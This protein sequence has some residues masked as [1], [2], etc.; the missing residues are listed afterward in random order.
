M[1]N[2]GV[3]KISAGE[4]VHGQAFYHKGHTLEG[5]ST[6]R[7]MS[8][9]KLFV[10]V[11]EPN[12]QLTCMGGLGSQ[13]KQLHGGC[14]HLRKALSKFSTP[15][16]PHEA[17]VKNL[18]E[19]QWVGQPSAPSNC[20]SKTKL[21]EDVL[22]KQPSVPPNAASETELGVNMWLH[23][24]SFPPCAAACDKELDEN[25]LPMQPSAPPCAP[26]ESELKGNTWLEQP[27]FNSWDPP[28]SASSA[29]ELSGH[30]TVM[31]RHIQRKYTPK[32][33]EWEIHKAG[34]MN[35]FDYLYIPSGSRKGQNRGFAF[36]NFAT[37]AIAETFRC[38]F[39]G[40]RFALY[41]TVRPLVIVPASIQGWADNFE[42]QQ[43]APTQAF[44]MAPLFLL[45]IC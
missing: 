41:P 2:W 32:L 20:V 9:V 30:T 16:L 5:S 43:A 26:C 8:S 12:Q 19:N 33:L 3:E 34:F 11:T 38:M 14:D 21:D 1:H 28:Q 24:Q 42:H 37:P 13:S 15:A 4:M 7:I 45:P 17:S 10:E 29:L 25:Q 44:R 35:Q 27:S 36:V 18:D 23:H 6:R 31:I 39:D 22:L 40:A